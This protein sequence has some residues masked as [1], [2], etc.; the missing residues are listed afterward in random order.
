MSAPGAGLV[1]YLPAAPWVVV[2][3]H[4]VGNRSDLPL[5]FEA[6]VQNGL[7]ATV[8]NTGGISGA[9]L[10]LGPFGGAHHA[11]ALLW[12]YTLLYVAAIIA[13]ATWAFSR[14]DL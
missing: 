7:N 11:G 8:S 3:A 9:L 12:P 5:P 10:D 2:P 4:G 1:A 6:L 14:R 13:A